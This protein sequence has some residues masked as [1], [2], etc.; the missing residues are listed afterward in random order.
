MDDATD[1]IANKLSQLLEEAR[2]MLEL[3][4]RVEDA[5][6]TLDP[7]IIRDRIERWCAVFAA[8]SDQVARIQDI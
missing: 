7:R 4:G 5:G 3:Q 1:M 6:L 2:M 8:V